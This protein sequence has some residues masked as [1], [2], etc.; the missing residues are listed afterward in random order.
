MQKQWTPAAMQMK[1]ETCIES[2]MWATRMTKHVMAMNK[3][4]QSRL[5]DL[6]QS[7]LLWSMET[8]LPPYKKI[9]RFL[10]DSSQ[11]EEED[12]PQSSF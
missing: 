6:M 3:N 2:R 4:L 9:K 5:L 12:Q 11:L 8:G 10:V 7:R 1:L